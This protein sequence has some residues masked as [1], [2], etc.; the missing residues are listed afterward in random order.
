M[1]TGRNDPCPCDSDHKFKKCCGKAQE[2]QYRTLWKR[3][4]D[5]LKLAGPFG[6]PY[7]VVM[8]AKC[9]Y[10]SKT[11]SGTVK[12]TSRE[13]MAS[14]SIAARKAGW[15]NVVDPDINPDLPWP[16]GFACPDCVEVGGKPPMEGAPGVIFSDLQMRVPLSNPMSE[17]NFHDCD[18]DSEE[19]S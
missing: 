7:G 10:C 4:L 15:R 13:A 3:S 2:G 18:C 12:D 14:F 5:H 17:H 16:S 8:K 9:D 11:F 1:K 6:T 19:A